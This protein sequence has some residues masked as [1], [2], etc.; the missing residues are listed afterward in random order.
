MDM[1]EEPGNIV[2]AKMGGPED[3]DDDKSSSTSTSTSNK[4][5]KKKKKKSKKGPKQASI[6]QTLSFV[7]DCGIKT[8]VLFFLPNKTLNKFVLIWVKIRRKCII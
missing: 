4:K 2:V 3:E 5:D 6:L 8:T 1:E 7:F